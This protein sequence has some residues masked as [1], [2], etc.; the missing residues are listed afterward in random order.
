MVISLNPLKCQY[1]MLSQI[2]SPADRNDLLESLSRLFIEESDIRIGQT[3]R[4]LL[5]DIV[6]RYKEAVIKNAALDSVRHQLFC[7]ALSKCLHWPDIKRWV[8]ILTCKAPRK[9]DNKKVTSA[10]FRKTFN[11][12]PI[13]LKN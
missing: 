7:V 12:H 11:I 6:S 5:L 2:W 4:P 9:A 8:L 1:F 3:L 13:M 10:K